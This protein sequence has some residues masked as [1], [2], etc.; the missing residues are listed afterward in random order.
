VNKLKIAVAILLIAAL[1]ALH[2]FGVLD[3]FA[4][5]ARLKQAI[6]ALGPWGQLAFVGSYTL[7]HPIGAPGTVF[8]FAAPLIWPWPTAYALSMV[9]TMAASVVGFSI[10]RFLG[11]DWVAGKLP[12]RARKYE[13]A[14][15]RRA[16]A[17]VVALRFLLWMPQW[18]QLFLGVS[19]VPFWTHFWGSLL[20]Y[21]VPL[22]L[23]SL[24]GEALLTFAKDLPIE[25]WLALAGVAAATAAVVWFAVRRR[26]HQRRLARTGPEPELPSPR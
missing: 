2:Q 14:L 12:A 18:L 20:G 16:F 15:E 11:R 9:G 4:D 26:R 1:I 3:S 19:K 6:L 22:L 17:T 10:A 21:A 25:G 5:P 13:A 8:V 24:F 7:L 23:V